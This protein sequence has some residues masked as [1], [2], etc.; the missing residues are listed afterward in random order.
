MGMPV[1]QSAA[2]WC[3]HFG[4]HRRP[5]VMTIGNFDGVHRGHQAI[6]RRVR[7]RAAEQGALSAVLT[8][9]PHPVRV[10]RPAAA[11]QLIETLAQRLRDLEQYGAEAVLVLR[12][13]AETARI[14]ADDFVRIFL[15]EAMRARGVLVGENFRFGHRQE[16]D[17]KMLTALGG[18]YS[19]EVGMVPPVEEGGVIISSSGIRQA[20]REGRVEDARKMLGRPFALEGEIRPGTGVGRK[21]VVPTLNLETAQELLP[22]NGVYATEAVVRGS[23]YRAATNIGTRPTFDG[24]R[25]AIESHLFGF[26]GELKDGPLEI[27]FHK[28][29]RE[30]RKFSGAEE[31]KAQVLRDVEAAGKYFG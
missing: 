22:K 21:L 7:E 11:P 26:S 8:F 12:F 15:A 23:V 30:E 27:R 9:Y 28:R 18:K 2:E 25:L 20:V 10:V 14:S 4:E 29:L 19:F 16:G 17:V 5:V 3:A 24:T 1:L 31:L 13:D 6:L